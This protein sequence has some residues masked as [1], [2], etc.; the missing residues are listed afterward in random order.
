MKRTLIAVAVGAILLGVVE[1]GGQSP[2]STDASTDSAVFPGNRLSHVYYL[3]GLSHYYNGEWAAALKAFKRAQR[4]DPESAMIT[5]QIGRAELRSGQIAEGIRSLSKAAEIGRENFAI[6][7]YVAELYL[8]A[9]QLEQAK[10][11]LERALAI[12]PKWSDGYRKLAAVYQ[13][14]G[15]PSGAAGILERLLELFPGDSYLHLLVV[16][17]YEQA[18]RPDKALPHLESVK[19]LAFDEPELFLVVAN[20]Y[21]KAGHYDEAIENYRFYLLDSPDSERGTVPLLA[22]YE[23]AERLPEAISYFEERVADNSAS[24]GLR[25]LLGKAYILNEQEKEGIGAWQS[26]IT[27]IPETDP[28]RVSKALR[29]YYQIASYY[30]EKE[31]YPA[32][33]SALEEAAGYPLTDVSDIFF[34]NFQL[35]T[36][37]RLLE[38]YEASSASF[39]RVLEAVESLDEA[40]RDAPAVREMAK[41]SRYSLAANY[42]LMGKE[43]Q[44]EAELKKTLEDAPDF[45]EANNYLAYFYAVR[46]RNLDRALELVERA[47]Q[48]ERKNAAF[49]DTLGWIYFKMDKPEEALEHLIEADALMDDPVIADHLGDT[50][51]ALGRM[52]E[53]AEAWERSLGLARRESADGQGMD[54]SYKSEDV[55]RKLEKALQQPSEIGG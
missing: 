46:G 36:L 27:D 14:E 17:L 50:Y 30:E 41:N 44:A 7:Q 3:Q 32:A 16:Q 39:L 34:V 43:D 13:H 5:Y 29:L 51:R 26:A 12:D 19:E 38:D 22:A 31:N 21:S 4:Y 52:E 47:L 20:T 54:P 9:G 35:G 10:P 1:A 6:Q 24:V 45:S 37:Y 25:L 55:E 18:R 48:K 2:N 23:K 28:E 11:Y 49:L 15:D 53:A 8:G 42:D 33:I 40:K